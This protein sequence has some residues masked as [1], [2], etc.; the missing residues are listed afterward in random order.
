MSEGSAS[1]PSVP[2]APTPARAGLIG[3]G[4]MGQGLALSLR[5]AGVPLTVTS[6]TRA[7]AEEVLAA[8]AE[9]VERPREVGR[10]VAGGVV[11]VMVPEAR[12]VERVLFGRSGLVKGAAPGTLVVNVGTIAPEESRDVAA[13]LAE[14]HLAY[15]EAPVGG[16]AD[17]ARAGSLLVFVGGGDAEFARAE[18]Y[19]RTFGRSLERMGEVGQGSAMKLVNNVLTVGTLELIAEA[20]TLAE[21]TGLP[22]E[23]TIDALLAGG[24]RSVVLEGKRRML[25]S[26]EYPSHFRL[27]LARKDLR[28]IER[29]AKDA[30][31]PLTAVREI[32]RVYDRAVKEG[33]ADLDFAAVFETVRAGRAAP[34][35]TGAGSGAPSPPAPSG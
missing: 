4:A 31:L 7:K 13:R 8:G 27:A 35:A 2:T 22:R 33:R 16:S 5:R 21:A 23:R 34:A 26:G 12:D 30:H 17:V 1:A 19:L 14:A 25:L 18:P 32:R 3:L 15:L 11:L 29:T 9:W 24:G 28:L 20:L 6:R 10:A